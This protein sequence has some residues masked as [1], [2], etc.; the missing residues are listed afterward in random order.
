[1]C[2]KLRPQAVPVD[3][4]HHAVSLEVRDLESHGRLLSS[5]S[6]WTRAAFRFLAV[7]SVR[8]FGKTFFCWESKFTVGIQIPGTQGQSFKTNFV[9]VK[10]KMGY[11]SWITHFWSNLH[12]NCFIGLILEHKKHLNSGILVKIWKGHLFSRNTSQIQVW[13]PFWMSFLFFIFFNKDWPQSE[14]FYLLRSFL[15]NI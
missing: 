14:L 9:K 12:Q 3:G 13:A 1:M 6:S 2:R 10:F 4:V 7:R 5:P 15:Q 8:S 11:T